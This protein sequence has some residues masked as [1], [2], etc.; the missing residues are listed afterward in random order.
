[1]KA[2]YSLLAKQWFLVLLLAM[3]LLGVVWPQPGLALYKT[4][5][6]KPFIFL[7]LLLPGILLNASELVR[8]LG[9]YKALLLSLAG[10]YVIL[11]ALY[12]LM[13]PLVGGMST[14]AGIGLLAMGAAPTTLAS[15]AVWT[16]MAGGN[17][18]LCIVMTVLS[19]GLNFLIG[20]LVLK[21]TLGRSH[22]F[23]MQEVMIELA[24]YVLL[25]IVLGQFVALVVKERRRAWERPLGVA[26][27]LLLVLVILQAASRASDQAAGFGLAQLLVLVAVCLAAHA[28]TAGLMELGGRAL[29]LNQSDRVA[30]VFVGG[31]KTLP[32]SIKLLDLFPGN[33]LGVISLVTYHALQLI[34]D[35]FLIEV[36]RRRIEAERAAVPSGALP[37]LE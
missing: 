11:P 2:I 28:A 4:V 20:P 32:V 21:A 25:P 9:S 16:R 34:F 12:F 3:V 15:A 10:T 5:G 1:M 6:H 14:P 24:L 33:G 13:A 30:A 27:R 23:S 36:F 17:T 31:Q 22:S 8:G 7:L 18:G 37:Q 35:T 29:G 26:S 19:N